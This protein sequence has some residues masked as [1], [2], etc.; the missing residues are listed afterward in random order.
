MTADNMRN[1]SAAGRLAAA[2]AAGR[3]EYRVPATQNVN[4]WGRVYM[5]GGLP[6]KLASGKSARWH[7]DEGA[8]VFPDERTGLP[9]AWREAPEGGDG[10]S[11]VDGDGATIDDIDYAEYL[12]RR[13]ARIA[14]GEEEEA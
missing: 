3:G 9:G 6:A 4:L 8:L 7:R 1:K 11:S 10:W 2:E 13:A 5:L 12:D 14:R